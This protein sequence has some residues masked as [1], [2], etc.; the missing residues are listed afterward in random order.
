MEF[1]GQSLASREVDQTKQ[2]GTSSHCSAYSQGKHL[3]GERVHFVQQ[4]TMRP[5]AGG[6]AGFTANGA[7]PVY[8]RMLSKLN[9]SL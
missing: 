8:M 2:F 9:S 6:F 5:Y 4:H 7:M 1:E 3:G